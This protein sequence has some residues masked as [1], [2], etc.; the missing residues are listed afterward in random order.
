M[1]KT[2]EFYV[3]RGT[4]GNPWSGFLKPQYGKVIECSSQTKQSV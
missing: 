3:Y 2:T 4:S 1:V